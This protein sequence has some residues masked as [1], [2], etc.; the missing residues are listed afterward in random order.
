MRFRGTWSS[1]VLGVVLACGN[2]KQDPDRDGTPPP[3][4]GTGNE[5]PGPAPTITALAP[6]WGSSAGGTPVK[7]TGS[8]F[9]A[10]GVTVTFG[11]NVAPNPTVVDDA[12]LMVVAPPNTIAPLVVHVTT[13]NGTADSA[14][15]FRYLAPLYAAD[16]AG[17]TIGRLYTVDPANAQTTPVGNIGFAVTGLAIS[18]DGRL[19]AAT[20]SAGG[21][22]VQSLITID[23]Y[24]GTGTLVGQLKDAAGA[25][26]GCADITFEATGALR[27]W[28]SKQLATIDITTGR[29]AL[30][31]ATL[32]GL[33]GTAG[34]GLAN[35]NGQLL[36][37]PNKGN[38]GLFKVNSATGAA[39]NPVTMNGPAQSVGAMTTVGPTLFASV[40]ATGALTT[41]LATINAQ[42]GVV[43]LKG[44]LPAKIDAIA[45]IP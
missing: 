12:T 45:G 33:A 40:T 24:T 35:V 14:I 28:H 20:N 13:A 4:D 25:V 21:T 31:T 38:G 37:A 7:I 15:K 36:V 41:Q 3:G 8:G 9:S 17:G 19:F 44:A 23:P 11:N 29:V 1:L 32:G 26:Q 2:V 42:T 10:A 43:T 27:G 39:V 6:D 16:G 18:P 30:A 22:A 34:N 5:M